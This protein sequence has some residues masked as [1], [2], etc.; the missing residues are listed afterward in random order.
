[1]VEHVGRTLESLG[2]V[3][4]RAAPAV[5]WDEFIEAET[6]LFGAWNG[7]SVERLA[8]ATGNQPGPDTLEATMITSLEVGRGLTA[9]QLMT[10]LHLVDRVTR[11]F[12]EFLQQWDLL[13]TPTMNVPPLPLGYFNGNDAALDAEGWTRRLFGPVSFAPLI[14]WAGL[15]AISLPLGSSADGL[16]IGVHLVAPMCDEATLFQVSGQLERT[17]PWAGRRAAFNAANLEG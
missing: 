11:T 1:M 15:P 10:D 2:H 8:L 5:D 6:R 12:G 14:N 7:W 4:E 3:V 9:F 17:L 13:L 16:P